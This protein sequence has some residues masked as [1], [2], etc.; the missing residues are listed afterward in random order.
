MLNACGLELNDFLLNERIL[1]RENFE[2]NF[3]MLRKMVEGRRPRRAPLFVLGYFT[4]ITGAKIPEEIKRK[5][6]E[7]AKWE[8][9][10]GYWLDDGFALKRKIYL[11]DF[12][13]KIHNH[14]FGQKTHPAIFKY[15]EED[16]FNSQVSVGINQFYE[17]YESGKIYKIKHV[18]LDGENLNYI[19]SE[20]F[21]LQNLKSLSIEHNNL[22]EVPNGISNLISLKYLYLCYN[23]LDRLPDSIGKLEKLKELIICHNKIDFLPESIKK[24]KNLRHIAV[25]G[26]KIREAPK[27]LKEARFDD[28]NK[29]IYF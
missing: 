1:T 19:P 13:R 27:F 9:E 7:A 20:I 3:N 22:K 14:K 8:H 2:K 28:L 26:T 6:L 29:T 18:N 5:I 24:L 25:I 15:T 16:F 11:N 21:E 10:E 23:Q 4:L 12:R 17:L